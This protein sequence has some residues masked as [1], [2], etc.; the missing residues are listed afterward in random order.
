MSE[1]V[2]D[3]IMQ[4]HREVESIFEKLQREPEVRA[5]LTPVLVTLLAAHSRAEESEV[6]PAARDEAG[7]AEDVAHSQE[8]HLLA[9]RLLAELSECDPFGDDYEKKLKEVV[10]AVTHHVEEEEKTVLPG[11]RSGLDDARRAELGQAFLKSRQEHLGDMPQDRTRAEM[12]QQAANA[13][14]PVGDKGKEALR[15]VLDEH[16]D[17]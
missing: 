1:D 3:L 10:D 9:D 16:A 15:D 6:Y 11:M 4:D 5:G 17:E 8:E 13:D 7:E 2:V 14:I 12:K